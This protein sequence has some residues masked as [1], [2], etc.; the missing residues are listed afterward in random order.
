[1]N[2]Y[3]QLSY[4]LSEMKNRKSVGIDLKPFKLSFISNCQNLVVFLLNFFDI[5]I[6]LNSF[7]IFLFPFAETLDSGVFQLFKP[8]PFVVIHRVQTCFWEFNFIDVVVVC[9]CVGYKT[10]SSD[11]WKHPL[12]T[13]RSRSGKMRSNIVYSKLIYLRW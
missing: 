10:T 6:L 1:M 7:D 13:H 3:K 9:Q 5:G 12:A 2:E 4:L 8:Q 11:I